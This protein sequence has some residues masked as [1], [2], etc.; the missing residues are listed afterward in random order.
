MNETYMENKGK[1]ELERLCEETDLVRMLPDGDDVFLEICAWSAVICEIRLLEV[2]N[3]DSRTRRTWESNQTE[4]QYAQPRDSR[5]VCPFEMPPKGCFTEMRSL[6]VLEGGYRLCFY[7][8]NMD[9]DQEISFAQIEYRCEPCNALYERIDSY[10]RLQTP[11]EYLGLV[12]RG[13]CCHIEYDVANEAELE[14]CALAEFLEI[15]QGDWE[16][17]K[18]PQADWADEMMQAAWTQAMQQAEHSDDVALQW[19]PSIFWNCAEECGISEV[20]EEYASGYGKLFR[21]L[22]K[23]KYEPL[24]RKIYQLL[25]ATQE[26]IPSH[27]QRC[28]RKEDLQAHREYVSQRLKEQGF[29]GEYPCFYAKGARKGP[30]LFFSYENTHI[31]F[32]EKEAESFIICCQ[33]DDKGKI[34]TEL[35]CGVKFHPWVEDDIFSCMFDSH[36]KSYFSCFSTWYRHETNDDEFA[37]GSADAMGNDDESAPNG[38]KNY[39]SVAVKGEVMPER[40]DEMTAFNRSRCGEICAAAAKSAQLSHLTKEEHAYK[41]TAR[42]WNSKGFYITCFLASMVMF[43]AL[44]TAGFAALEAVLVFLFTQSGA[45]VAECFHATPWGILFVATGTLYALPM[46]ICTYLAMRK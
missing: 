5:E 12:A 2:Q 42:V 28:C 17:Q 46:T 34:E 22:S 44:M 7:N 8:M 39:G 15:L 6:T 9:E 25:A 32:R 4:P 14:I 1:E 13:I 38:K 18:L 37:M 29:E 30:S 10:T 45:D 23:E 35:F 31:A 3:T 24:W 11:W 33:Q 36:G 43:G 19:I 41:H 26:G 21:E 16:T 40:G 27:A 20:I